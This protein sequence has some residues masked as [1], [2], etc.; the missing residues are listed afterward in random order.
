MK[1]APDADFWHEMTALR[2]A[3]LIDLDKC[4]HTAKTKKS[5]LARRNSVRAAFAAIEG[6]TWTLKLSALQL[7]QRGEI[8]FSSGERALLTEASYELDNKGQVKTRPAR[9]S[10]L[11]NIRF[12]VAAFAKASAVEFELLSSGEKWDAFRRAI[13]IRDRLVHPKSIHEFRVTDE[14]FLIV[15]DAVSW[16]TAEISRLLQL[17]MGEEPSPPDAKAQAGA[18]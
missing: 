6:W 10:L 7:E 4:L 12:A 15:D 2:F 8:E 14:D 9:L 11:T 5:Q 13:K 18:E 1:R 17:A 3:L 16:W